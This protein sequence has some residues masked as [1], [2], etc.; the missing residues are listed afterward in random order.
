MVVR[1]PGP[2]VDPTGKIVLVA[3]RGDDAVAVEADDGGDL[4]GRHT[5]GFFDRMPHGE[6]RGGSDSEGDGDVSLRTGRAP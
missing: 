5:E 3:P 4:H 2:E 1:I 6:A